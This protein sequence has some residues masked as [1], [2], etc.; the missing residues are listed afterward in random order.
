VCRKSSA[1]ATH[2]EHLP[3]VSAQ[4][5]ANAEC[6]TIVTNIVTNIVKGKY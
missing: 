1:K 4:R 3:N 6:S 2:A 5:Y